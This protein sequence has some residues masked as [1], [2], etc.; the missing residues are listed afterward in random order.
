MTVASQ[1]YGTLNAPGQVAK[2]AAARGLKVL[3]VIYLDPEPFP[4][5]DSIEAGKKLALDYPDTIKGLV[6]GNE[7]RR[8]NTKAVAEMLVTDCLTQL[9]GERRDP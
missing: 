8:R 6:C 9:R 2:L 3:Q 4:V 5:A 1:V 7:V